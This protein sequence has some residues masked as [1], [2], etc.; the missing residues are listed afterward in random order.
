MWTN[1]PRSYS[2]RAKD[3]VYPKG[4]Q[5]AIRPSGG[6]CN[7]SNLAQKNSCYGKYDSSLSGGCTKKFTGRTFTLWSRKRRSESLIFL[8]E[9]R[10]LAKF[11]EFIA[12][13]PNTTN[14]G[15]QMNCSSGMVAGL[16]DVEHHR[17]ILSEADTLT[18]LEQKLG[19][20]VSLETMDKSTPYLNNTIHSVTL[21][22]VQRSD[23]KW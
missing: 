1:G 18:V 7:T 11:C 13:F 6:G 15:W 9:L 8:A 5:A 19:R 22:N 17:K 3:G 4:E 23:C 20:L 10:T 16:A 21:S 2:E 14:C 12:A